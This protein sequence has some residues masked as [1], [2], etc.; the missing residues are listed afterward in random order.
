[1]DFGLSIVSKARVDDVAKLVQLSEDNGFTHAWVADS[2]FLNRDVYAT[3]ALA[4]KATSKIILGPGVASIQTRHLSV[5]AAAMISIDEISNGRAIL[6]IGAG[7]S[8]SYTLGERPAT[9]KDCASSIEIL[10]K[11]LD[12]EEVNFGNSKQKMKPSGNKIP[13]YFASNS[14]N[15]LRMA[16]K[17]A[18]GVIMGVTARPEIIRRAVE[19]VK[20]GVKQRG[21]KKEHFEIVCNFGTAMNDNRTQ[22]LE[23]ARPYAVLPAKLTALNLIGSMDNISEELRRLKSDSEQI[24]AI[25]DLTKYGSKANEEAEKKVT[26]QMIESYTVA[27]TPEDVLKQIKR[28]SEQVPDID[29]IWITPANSH[30]MKMEDWIDYIKKFGDRVISR[31]S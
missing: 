4:A 8:S 20:E 18:D 27:G 26:K 15:M 11:L 25:F 7:F 12:G 19:F 30:N 2:P 6:G 17:Y 16:G 24:K 22:A 10:R 1:M 9:V 5:T 28:N 14:P 3:L 29:Q 23:E 13:I 21:G 31:F